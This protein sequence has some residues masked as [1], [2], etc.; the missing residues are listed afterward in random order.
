M[1][2]VYQ[3]LSSIPPA[4]FS[5]L[6]D[7]PEF[8]ISSS[9]EGDLPDDGRI[10]CASNLDNRLREIQERTATSAAPVNTPEIRIELDHD[11]TPREASSFG[12]LSSGLPNVSTTLH[13]SNAKHSIKAHPKHTSALLRLLYL[14]SCIN[15]AN[16]SPHLPSLFVPLYF[17]SLQEIEPSDLAHAEADT[18]WLFEAMISEF[19]ELDDEGG[20]LWM[21]KFSD[22]LTWA[23]EELAANLV[24][25][26]HVL[27]IVRQLPHLAYKRIGSCSPTLFAVRLQLSS[28]RCRCHIFFSRWLA[29]LLTQTLPLSSVIL[30]WDALFSRPKGDR[31]TNP[32][33]DFLLDICTSMLIRARPALFRLVF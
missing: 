1:L 15:P 10:D 29:P 26:T 30:V 27:I 7:E 21:R 25:S 13:P 24:R 6:E 14:H 12:S 22:R 9:L 31:E 16:L 11:G 4:L 5:G 2:N 23:D 19:S 28:S 20:S 18:F 8:T 3:Q 17:I 33:L 32:K